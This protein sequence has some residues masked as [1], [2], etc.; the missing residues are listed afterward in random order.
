[1]RNPDF[2]GRSEVGRGLL[3]ADL[4]NDGGM[5][6]VSSPIGSRARVFH[7]TALGRGAWLGI[8]AVLPENGGRYAYGAVVD[9]TANG[10]VFRS[11]VNSGYSYLCSNDPRVHVGL[12]DLKRYEKIAV[13]WPDRVT[14]EFGGGGVNRY[15]RLEK[16]TGVR[17]N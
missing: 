15:I 7:N 2:T 1:M 8:S 16:G 3:A 9:I 12:G 10:K 4:D 11:V 6:L 14:E 17:G 13:T 5:D